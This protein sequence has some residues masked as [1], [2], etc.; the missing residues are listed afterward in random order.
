LAAENIRLKE[1][2]ARK[3]SSLLDALASLEVINSS[4]A[5]S[6]ATGN[7]KKSRV[8]YPTLPYHT[9]HG[10]MFIIDDCIG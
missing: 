1:E 8:P 2:L 7:E 5:A 6:A 9:I 10:M 3:T 4:T